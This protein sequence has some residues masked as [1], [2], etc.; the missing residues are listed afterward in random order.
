MVACL[1]ACERATFMHDQV[2]VCTHI[3]HVCVCVCVCVCMKE[4][5]TACESVCLYVHTQAPAFIHVGLRAIW[6][7]TGKTSSGTKDQKSNS[8]PCHNHLHLPWRMLFSG[9]HTLLTLWASISATVKTKRY[10]SFA[11][12]GVRKSYQ[13]M[14]WLTIYM[15]TLLTH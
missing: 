6:Q 8:S 14:K 1:W 7:W 3:S 9:T 5:V 2:R 13:I 15:A 10:I 4:C 11:N 12:L